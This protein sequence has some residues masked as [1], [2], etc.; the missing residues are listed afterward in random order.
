MVERFIAPV[1][2]SKKVLGSELVTYIGKDTQGSDSRRKEA[3][4]YLST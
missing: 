1:L 3:R 2:K 4:V